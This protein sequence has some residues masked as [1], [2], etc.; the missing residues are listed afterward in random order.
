MEIE[1]IKFLQFNNIVKLILV[2]KGQ[3]VKVE[4]FYNNHVSTIDLKRN[5]LKS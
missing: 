5:S 1:C 3:T 4:I 2:T